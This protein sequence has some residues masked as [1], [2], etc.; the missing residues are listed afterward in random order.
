MFRKGWLASLG[1]F[2]AVGLVVGLPDR[3]VGWFGCDVNCPYIPNCRSGHCGGGDYYIGGKACRCCNN[4]GV[5]LRQPGPYV[6]YPAYDY[7]GPCAPGMPP[8]NPRSLH[9]RDYR[10]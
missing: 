6:S 7:R 10:Q 4:F 3:A 1:V 2:V 5:G 9:L 8:Q